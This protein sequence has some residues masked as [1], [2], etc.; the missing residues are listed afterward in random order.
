MLAVALHFSEQLKWSRESV[1]AGCQCVPG[2]WLSIRQL[3]W[4]AKLFVPQ[5]ADQYNWLPISLAWRCHCISSPFPHESRVCFIFCECVYL[6]GEVRLGCA[7]GKS[8]NTLVVFDLV[9]VWAHEIF[10]V[11]LNT[12]YIY[13]CLHKAH[14]ENVRNVL[15][16]LT[17][18]LKY[19][20]DIATLEL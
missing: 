13:A 20:R 5:M 10:M 8:E 12:K 3:G 2:I 15:Y 9:Y 6:F 16:K 1:A 14:R 4:V 7:A 17:H 19:D 18:A 11:N